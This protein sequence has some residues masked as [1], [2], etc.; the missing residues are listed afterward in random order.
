MKQQCDTF[1]PDSTTAIV[2]TEQSTII[3]YPYEYACTQPWTGCRSVRGCAALANSSVHQRQMRGRQDYSYSDR[4]TS[5]RACNTHTHTHRR[6]QRHTLLRGVQWKKNHT[7]RPAVDG[8][9]D[10][11]WDYH[12]NATANGNNFTEE[13][14]SREHRLV[15][16]NFEHTLPLELVQ[17]IRL[18][19]HGSSLWC[20][21]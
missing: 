1:W 6:I 11:L 18:R 15:R 5:T 3:E 7:A 12:P 2:G 10:E 21:V 17:S 16:S 14:S 9:T 20:D 19:H 13:A 4:E 8:A